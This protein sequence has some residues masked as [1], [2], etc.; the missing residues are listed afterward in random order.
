MSLD[1]RARATTEAAAHNG[2]RLDATTR[3]AAEKQQCCDTDYQDA[4]ET[5]E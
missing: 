1:W 4:P 3:A 2:L 5:A